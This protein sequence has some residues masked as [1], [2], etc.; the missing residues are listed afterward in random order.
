M[1]LASTHWMLVTPPLSPGAEPPWLRAPDSAWPCGERV[2]RAAGALGM[3]GE[4]FPSSSDP[5]SALERG[6]GP[7]SLAALRGPPGRVLTTPGPP[8]L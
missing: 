6:L 5:R 3:Q 7:C 1:S 4:A 2:V 8:E